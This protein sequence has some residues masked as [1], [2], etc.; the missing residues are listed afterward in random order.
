MTNQESKKVEKLLKKFN[1]KICQIAMLIVD[2]NYKGTPVTIEELKKTAEECLA[3][4]INSGYD[5]FSTGG[6]IVRREYDGED[7]I[8]ISLTFE[9]EKQWL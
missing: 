9:L 8:G 4:L 7:F 6:F 5:E 2:W 1:F 3:Q